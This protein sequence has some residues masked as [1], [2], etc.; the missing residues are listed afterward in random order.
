MTMKKKWKETWKNCV[1]KGKVGSHMEK[2]FY[3]E[4]FYCVNDN[5]KVDLQNTQIMRCIHCNQNSVIGINPKTHARK[6][7][8][9][10][11]KTG[12]ITSFKEHED[13]DHSFITERFEEKW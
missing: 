8:I 4:F 7:S 11:C 1:R 9:S 12:G 13:A 5:V 10:Y 6:W 2:P 3:V